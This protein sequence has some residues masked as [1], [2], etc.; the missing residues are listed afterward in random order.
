MCG[1]ACRGLDPEWPQSGAGPVSL[2]QGSGVVRI[3]KSLPGQNQHNPPQDPGITW[4]LLPQ[5][6]KL[7]KTPQQSLEGERPVCSGEPSF[8]MPWISGGWTGTRSR[9]DHCGLQVT[10]GCSNWLNRTGDSQACPCKA[11]GQH[12]ESVAEQPPSWLWYP[13]PPGLT[14]HTSRVPQSTF[15]PSQVWGGMGDGGGRERLLPV[16]EVTGLTAPA[17]CGRLSL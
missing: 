3:A 4:A 10:K 7:E 1:Q 17:Q 12:V 8:N 15:S 11:R 16:T 2:A 5:H 6:P 9:T 14:I 13:P